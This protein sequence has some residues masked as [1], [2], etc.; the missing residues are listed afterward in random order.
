MGE[1]YAQEAKE[2]RTKTIRGVAP[3]GIIYDRNGIILS[4]NRP[5]LVISVDPEI[6]DDNPEVLKRLALVLGKSYYNLERKLSD[7]REYIKGYIDIV[8]DIDKELATFIKEHSDEFPGVLVK[9]VPLRNY[10][11]GD[12]SSHI[13]GYV[14]QITLEELQQEKFKYGYHPGDVVGNFEIFKNLISHERGV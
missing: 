8:E 2:I 5:G 6:I 3:R 14:G 11:N 13:L 1:S 9:A 12:I 10:P 7:E 4:Y